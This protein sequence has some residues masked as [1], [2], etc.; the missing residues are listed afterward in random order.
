ME[1]LFDR[2][3]KIGGAMVLTGVFASQF[4]FV[5]DGGERALKMSAIRGLQNTVYGEGI[6]LRI[7]G[8]DNIIRFEIRSQ[9]TLLHSTTGTRD[10]QQVNISMRLLFRPVEE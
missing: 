6:H 1:R 3:G 9:P 5:V 4:T 2:I 10:M 8:I 7:P